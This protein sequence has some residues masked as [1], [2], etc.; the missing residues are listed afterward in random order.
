M[1]INYVPIRQVYVYGKYGTN[2][3]MFDTNVAF[4]LSLSIKWNM[5]GYYFNSFYLICF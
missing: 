4:L 1:Q 2:L 3:Q 5:W